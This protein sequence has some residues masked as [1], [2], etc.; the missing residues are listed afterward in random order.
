MLLNDAVN[1]MPMAKTRYDLKLRLHNTTCCQTG[2]QTA[3]TNG[4]I[5]Y[6]ASCTTRFDN[7]LNE[8]CC[9]FNTV[10]K[11]AVKPV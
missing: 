7:R 2:C 9:S 10:V 5:V 3:L 6:T 4:C 11:P 1:D 8:Q